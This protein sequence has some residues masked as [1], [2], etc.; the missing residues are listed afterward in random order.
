MHDRHFF[1]SPSISFSAHPSILSPT[2]YSTP[3]PSVSTSIYAF[4]FVFMH[5]RDFRLVL[6]SEWLCVWVYVCNISRTRLSDAFSSHFHTHSL[7]AYHFS[8]IKAIMCVVDVG[9]FDCRK[10][11]CSSFRGRR[12]ERTHKKRGKPSNKVYDARARWTTH[13]PKL[14]Q[15]K[16]EHREHK[17]WMERRLGKKRR[18]HTPCHAIMHYWV[19]HPFQCAI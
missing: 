19:P 17:N 1:Y 5:L 14:N 13:E 3:Y 15:V 10:L 9:S 12:R 7:C 4:A 2:C 16:S 11:S 18:P 6:V 8:G